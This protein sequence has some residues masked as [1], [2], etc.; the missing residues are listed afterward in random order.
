MPRRL[1]VLAEWNSMAATVAAT[2]DLF[3]NP[4]VPAEGFFAEH[5]TT[6][7]LVWPGLLAAV[8]FVLAVQRW[9]GLGR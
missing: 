6:M 8:F 1:G 9:R 7:A 4:G 5:A 3:G 2:R